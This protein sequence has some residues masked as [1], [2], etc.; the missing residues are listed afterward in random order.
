MNVHFFRKQNFGK[1]QLG[2]W[3]QSQE[4]FVG[5]AN[6]SFTHISG[7]HDLI[8]NRLLNANCL[9]LR[10]RNR[11]LEGNAEST[12]CLLFITLLA[13][14]EP[15]FRFCWLTEKYCFIVLISLLGICSDICC[16]SYQF[17][18]S[19]YVATQRRRN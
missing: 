8:N 3:N 15:R 2:N 1:S 13:I 17:V 14:D 9:K 19:M 16:E 12:L 4:R 18:L 11:N 7:S 10:L 6:I 5:L